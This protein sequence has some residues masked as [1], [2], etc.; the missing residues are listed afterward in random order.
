MI[1]VVVC[2][3]R[4]EETINMVKSALLFNIDK[5]PLRF[6]IITEDG[7]RDRLQEK[8]DDWRT[9][10]GI[11]RYDLMPLTFPKNN[12]AQWK[13]LFKPCAAQ[14]LFLPVS[15]IFFLTRLL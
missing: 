6:V 15:I 12:E 8:L 1:A 4:F 5:N 14:R 7:I 10:K 2:G 9:L 3:Q 13:T 11:F